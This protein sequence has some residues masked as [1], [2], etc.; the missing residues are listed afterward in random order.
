[1]PRGA[2]GRER[3]GILREELPLDA[4]APRAP[5]RSKGAKTNVAVGAPHV[6]RDADAK[7]LVPVVRHAV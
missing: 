2:V 7:E 4:G 3:P 5:T 1:M 6:A